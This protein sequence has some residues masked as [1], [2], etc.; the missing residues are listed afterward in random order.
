M[1]TDF[2]TLGFPEDVLAKLERDL[3]QGATPIYLVPEKA[4]TLVEI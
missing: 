4:P 3:P 1:V 2:D